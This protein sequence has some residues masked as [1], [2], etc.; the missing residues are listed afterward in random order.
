MK[1]IASPCPLSQAQIGNKTG[2]PRSLDGQVTAIA[3]V[4]SSPNVLQ[5]FFAET[6]MTGLGRI[7]TIQNLFP[8]GQC[9]GVVRHHRFPMARQPDRLP[10]CRSTAG[11]NRSDICF[12]WRRHPNLLERPQLELDGVARF[13][14]SAQLSPIG[15]MSAT[16]RPVKGEKEV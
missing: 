16:T 10:Y 11:R 6:D 7:R 14:T 13:P 15:M 3:A 2:I 4:Q 5:A 12:V 1:F 9:G 8:T